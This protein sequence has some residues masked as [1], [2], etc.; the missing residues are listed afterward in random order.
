MICN[1]PI[2]ISVNGRVEWVN[3]GGSK[4]SDI[5]ICHDECSAGYRNLPLNIGD[6][7]FSQFYGG[8]EYVYSR[9][10]E[11]EEE[12]PHIADKIQY[13]RKQLFE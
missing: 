4:I 9:L 8:E 6:W 5:H 7:I 11:M 1:K 10:N 12:N 13:I 2:E 3:Q